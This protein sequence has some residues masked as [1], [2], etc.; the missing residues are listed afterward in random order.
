MNFAGEVK[1]AGE[2]VA[3]RS[4]CVILRMYTSGVPEMGSELI[5]IWRETAIIHLIEQ[6]C[7]KVNGRC[8]A[9]GSWAG[10][11]TDMEVIVLLI[12]LVVGGLYFYTHDCGPH[13]RAPLEG[14]DHHPEHISGLDFSRMGRKPCMGSLVHRTGLAKLLA[15]RVPGESGRPTAPFREWT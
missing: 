6:A 5:S 11:S 8:R 2:D 13:A 7:Q 9:P 14:R 1:V 15:S 12:V 10:G 3:P 4:H